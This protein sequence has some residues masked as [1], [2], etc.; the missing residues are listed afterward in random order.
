M[1][2]TLNLELTP[3]NLEKLKL[4]TSDTTAMVQTP[5]TPHTI[6]NPVPQPAVQ[7]VPP[8]SQAPDFNTAT[9]LV[10]STSVEVPVTKTAL[11]EAATSLLKA[12]KAEAVQAIFTQFGL[13]KLSDADSR[14]EIYKDLLQALECANG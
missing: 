11:K 13:S 8:L 4:F 3:E 2:I 10:P 5:I 6:P 14:P 12:G 1:T 7:T 9:T